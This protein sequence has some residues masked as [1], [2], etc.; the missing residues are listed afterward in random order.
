MSLTTSF[1]YQRP[2]TVATDG[3]D[4]FLYV[5]TWGDRHIEVIFK[6]QKDADRWSDAD[7]FIVDRSRPLC[8]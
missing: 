3:R 8:R 2:A 6:T 4:G 1:F 5:Y 7:P